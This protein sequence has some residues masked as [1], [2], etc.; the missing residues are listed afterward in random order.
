MNKKVLLGLG[1]GLAGATALITKKL[2][3]A[4]QKEKMSEKIDESLLNGREKALEY[5]EYV[6]DYLDD[7]DLPDFSDLKDKVK[8]N[9]AK[10]AENEKIVDAISN[11]KQATDDLRDK[12]S[13]MALEKELAEDQ[14]EDAIVIDSA[15]FDELTEKPVEV[16]YPKSQ[17]PVEDEATP[18]EPTE[19]EVE[20]APEEAPVDTKEDVK[21]EEKTAEETKEEPKTETKE[22][23]ETTK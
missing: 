3:T 1:I 15:I 19:D 9:T 21:T 11:L 14:Y 6:E 10:I 2:V 18:V 22:T 20:N 16:F 8:S 12:L 5:Y 7:K 4:E 13:D 17:Q 23:V